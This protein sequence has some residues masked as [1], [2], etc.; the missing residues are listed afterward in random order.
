MRNQTSVFQHFEHLFLSFEIGHCKPETG[1]F[2]IVLE[3]VS[4]L[5]ADI[6]FLDDME[7]NIAA[8]RRLGIKALQV[9][10]S[11]EVLA[12]LSGAGF[13]VS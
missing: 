9:D 5:P 4:V 6:L 11:V 2:D 12:A 1:A 13:D 3:G 8:A 10:G 7:Q